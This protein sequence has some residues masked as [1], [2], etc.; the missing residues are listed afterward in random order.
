MM[1]G[2]IYLYQLKQS[3]Y[4][5]EQKQKLKFDVIDDKNS[6]LE[7]L[8]F[9]LN[10]LNQLKYSRFITVIVGDCEQIMTIK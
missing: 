3:K 8:N 2:R 7:K 1:N 9:Y 6:S 5:I 10:P 4:P